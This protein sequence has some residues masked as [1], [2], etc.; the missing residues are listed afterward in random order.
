MAMPTLPQPSPEPAPIES[1]RD[2]PYVGTI[3]LA[4]DATDVHRRIFNVRQAIPVAQPGPLT[5][6]YP[7]WLPGYHSPEAPIELFAGLVIS[8][9]GDRIPWRRDP[10][11]VHAFHIDV[12]EGVT[13]IEAAFQFLS[14]TAEAQGRIVVTPEMLNLQWNTVILY[15]AGFFSRRITVEA[16][17]TLPAGWHFGCA[18]EVGTASGET[19]TFEP[20]PLDV[21]VDSPMFAGRHFR[22]IELDGRGPVRLNIV[23][24][25]ADLLAASEE[26]IMPHRALIA[27]ADALFGA[28]HFD[29]YDF[30]LALSDEL[31]AI[32][33]EHH[34]SSE[35]ATVPGYFTEWEKSA[36][37]RD[38]IAHEYT[39]SW[40]GKFRRGADSWTPTFE[41]PIR[42]SL[43]WV[44]E[45]QTQYWGQVLAARSG[46]WTREMAIEALAQTAASY[47]I[48]L[49]R[50]WRPMS[51]TT[52]D[53]IIAARAP[54]PWASWQRSE[55]YYSEGQLVW[56]EIDT[57]LRELT[58]DARSLDDFAAAFFGTDDG[59]YVTKPYDFGEVVR[60]LQNLARYDWSGFL[61]A[62]LERKGGG[63]PLAGIDR[64][65]YR[66]V[67]KDTP[68][69][70]GARSDAVLGS[71]NLMF[72]MGVVLSAAGELK[73]VIWGG[74]AFDAGLTVG[75]TL[76]AV[77][78]HD[79]SAGELKRAITAAGNGGPIEL[80]VRSGK[81]HR[82]VRIEYSGGLRYPH[83]EPI[84]ASRR[85]DQILAPRCP[86]ERQPAAEQ[87]A[88]AEPE[89]AP[90]SLR[91]PGRI[92]PARS[93]S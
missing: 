81:R 18:L 90:L 25:N 33:V 1:P 10:V 82:T 68:S 92:S 62:K 53:P 45:G 47:D 87:T 4:V 9:G 2:I 36:P 65:G 49:G 28:R 64:G 31:G 54:I 48:R 58:N 11:E 67:Y 71:V 59:S 39:H 76:V 3:R 86:P 12:P 6:L 80:I 24:D 22:R 29:H 40:N 30:L 41:K 83:L 43:M 69:D 19:T 26:Q 63:A 75:S 14:P 56:L 91:E 85:L 61:T 51:D 27:E 16:T 23:A 42:N 52:R 17:V 44:Y 20:V 21:L 35:T 66:L 93:H 73:E 37:K 34:R 89:P 32:G 13:E 77:N 38:T 46:L 84:T 88:S 70:Y 72:S 15:P 5:L 8:A 74:P 78:G 79:Y 7:K 57:L 55:D 50:N 60:T